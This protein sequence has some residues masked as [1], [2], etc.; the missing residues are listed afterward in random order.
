M[1]R[2]RATTNP[3]CNAITSQRKGKAAFK[4]NMW[5]QVLLLMTTYSYDAE[6]FELVSKLGRLIDWRQN[7]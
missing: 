3:L 2:N 7:I 1:F 4:T 5:A 6:T